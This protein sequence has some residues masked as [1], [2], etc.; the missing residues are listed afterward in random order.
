MARHVCMLGFSTCA[1]TEKPEAVLRV[2]GWVG[3]SGCQECC[4][5][6]RGGGGQAREWGC[7]PASRVPEF[8]S[9]LRVGEVLCHV[10]SVGGLPLPPITCATWA[11]RPTWQN[12]SENC[13]PQLVDV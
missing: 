8:C 2:N 12:P 1:V 7:D 13:H 4:A 11:Q 5:S 3:T 10:S 6:L 9:C